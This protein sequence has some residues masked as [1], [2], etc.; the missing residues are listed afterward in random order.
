MLAIS[1]GTL[2]LDC[3]PL[4]GFFKYVQNHSSLVLCVRVFF[5]NGLQLLSTCGEIICK[6]AL[7]RLDSAKKNMLRLLSPQSFSFR[8]F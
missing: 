8:D 7:S 4:V 6:I 3:A 5:Y 1:P 2:Q